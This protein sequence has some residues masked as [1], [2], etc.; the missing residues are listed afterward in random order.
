MTYLVVIGIETPRIDSRCSLEEE[1][2]K[3]ICMNPLMIVF[4]I[5]NQVDLRYRL[6]DMKFSKMLVW[7]RW[8]FPTLVFEDIILR[9]EMR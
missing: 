8:N 7:S 1:F 9:N 6:N 3:L 4:V 5:F 2:T